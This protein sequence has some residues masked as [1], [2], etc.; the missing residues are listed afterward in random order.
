MMTMTILLRH[1]RHRHLHHNINHGTKNLLRERREMI[2]HLHRL[3][4]FLW[5][6]R[7][8]VGL[9]NQI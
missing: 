5:N 8:M 3:G 4:I 7:E 1:R 9:N 2:I 6:L